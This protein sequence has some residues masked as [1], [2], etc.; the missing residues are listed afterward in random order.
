MLH[1]LYMVSCY[2]DPA[3]A[4]LCEDELRERYGASSVAEAL[5]DGLIERICTP[6]NNGRFRFFCRLSSLGEQSVQARLA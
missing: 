6:C 1:D 4:V 3:Q 5:R 2:F